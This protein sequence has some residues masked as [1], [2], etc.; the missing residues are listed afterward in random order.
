MQSREAK[1]TSVYLKEILSEVD[2][3]YTAVSEE[4]TSFLR[5]SK[6]FNIEKET[7][8]DLQQRGQVDLNYQNAIVISILIIFIS[9]N[10]K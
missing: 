4:M 10:R 3:E 1:E 8:A 9:K 6:L 7:D 5:Q 2:R